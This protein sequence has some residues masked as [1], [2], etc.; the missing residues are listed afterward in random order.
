MRPS[1][2]WFTSFFFRTMAVGIGGGGNV[3]R[4]QENYILVLSNHL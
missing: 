4:Y 1:V 2:E 3:K